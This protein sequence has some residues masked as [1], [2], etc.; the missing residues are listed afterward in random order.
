[1]YTIMYLTTLHNYVFNDASLIVCKPEVTETE[2]DT[3]SS[4]LRRC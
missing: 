4:S 2:W 3:S 1:M